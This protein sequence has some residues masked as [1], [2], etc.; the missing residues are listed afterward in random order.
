MLVSQSDLARP[1]DI[2]RKLVPTRHAAFNRLQLKGLMEPFEWLGTSGQADS[3]GSRE[4]AARHVDKLVE[5][6]SA[7]AG[8]GPPL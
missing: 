4:I 1:R 6:A 7:C 2:A 5:A 3:A 8:C